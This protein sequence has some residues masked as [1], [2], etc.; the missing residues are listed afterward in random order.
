[1]SAPK[2]PTRYRHYTGEH[3][4]LIAEA[5]SAWP[6][7]RSHLPLDLVVYA[8]L[9]DGRWWVQPAA[10]F[11]GTVFVA[12]Q[13]IQPFERVGEDG[14]HHPE[15]ALPTLARQIATWRRRA[16][17]RRTQAAKA[18]AIDQYDE[19]IRLEQEAEIYEQ[20]VGEAERVQPDPEAPD[21]D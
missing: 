13:R 19:A 6:D 2:P 15:P 7:P 21:A 16:E 4:R 17:C 8:S 12:G 18:W 11:F 3:F 9:A 10:E 14:D 5:L 1:M 20:V